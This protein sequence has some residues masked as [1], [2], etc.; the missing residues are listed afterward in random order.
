[1]KED[2]CVT[3]GAAAAG[4]KSTEGGREGGPPIP[5]GIAG[6][7][8]AN[9]AERERERERGGENEDPAAFVIT[10]TSWTRF[11]G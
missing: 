1:M 7:C 4:F 8:N 6:E 3:E 2:Y 11:I 9:G 10:I 5:R